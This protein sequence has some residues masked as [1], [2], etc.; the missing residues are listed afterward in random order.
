MED[1]I[2]RTEEKALIK[3]IENSGEPEL[4]AVYGR[5][6]IGKTFLIR[7]GFGQSLA[8]VFSGTHNAALSQELESFSLAL[9]NVSGGLQLARPISWIQ[10]FQ[11]LIQ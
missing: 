6:R 4:L 10:A 8:F 9:T 7:N 3:R 1:V 11:M 2:G 5:R